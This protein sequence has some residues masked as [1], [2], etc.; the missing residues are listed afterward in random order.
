LFEVWVNIEEEKL[1]YD[2]QMFQYVSFAKS[3][4]ELIQKLNIIC[5]SQGKTNQPKNMQHL[6]ELVSMEYNSLNFIFEREKKISFLNPFEQDSDTISFQIP[7]EKKVFVL[8][9]NM[10]YLLIYFNFTKISFVA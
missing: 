3:D 5:N 9:Y 6:L 7:D 10:G 1:N 4:L 2:D 8:S